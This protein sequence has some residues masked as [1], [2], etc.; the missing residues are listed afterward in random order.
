MVSFKKEKINLYLS[1]YLIYV[2]YWKFYCTFFAIINTN[3][4]YIVKPVYKSF[5]WSMNFIQLLSLGSKC[6]EKS[7]I[8]S[9]DVMT[10]EFLLLTCFAQGM[11]NLR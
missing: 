5:L 6:E 11:D 2:F 8:L 7:Y 10:S 4:M 1:V 3:E 9:Y